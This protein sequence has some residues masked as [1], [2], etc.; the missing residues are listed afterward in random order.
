MTQVTLSKTDFLTYLD[1]PLHLWAA[2]HE[3]LED[4]T[5]DDY[6]RH[7]MT[8]GQEVE[9]LAQL[10]VEQVLRPRYARAE[11]Y[12]QRHFEDGPFL[13][14]ADFA[15]LDEEAGVYDLYEVKSSSSVKKEHEFDIAFQSLV[16]AATVPLRH[17][18]ILHLNKEYVRRGE[19]DI[20]DLFVTE[21]VDE[22]VEKRLPEVRAQRQLALQ[23]AAQP[24][25]EGLLNCLKPRTCPCPATCHP[26]LPEFPIYEIPRLYGNKAH[27]LQQQGIYAQDDIPPDFKLSDMQQLVVQAS[28]RRQPIIDGPAIREE[29]A[30]LQYPLYFIDYEA[31][32]PAVPLFDGYHPFQQIVFQYS[33]HVVQAPG[34]APRHVECL[35]LENADPAPQLVAHMAEHI[36]DTGSVLVWSKAFEATRNKEMAELLPQYADFLLD[37][38]R[39]IYD[40]RD[41][42]S[43]GYYVHPEFHGSTSIKYVLPVLAPDLSYHEEQISSG[44]Q[45][46]MAW[47]KIIAGEISEAE[48]AQ[49]RRDLLSYCELDTL[50]M[51][52]I[53]QVLMALVE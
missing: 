16:C 50:A 42:F 29:L 23:A 51:V 9:A 18:Y 53:W 37:L 27:Q 21:N 14:R 39:R 47:M 33:L 22:I 34:T 52:R 20:A 28:R 8:Q 2:K 1:A 49:I 4:T 40:L 45:A 43:K 24:E 41:I 3:R 25:P 10:Y 7:L 35:L 6:T 44:D 19:I 36:G 12:P 30:A 38:N 5:P 17:H 31:Y 32:N 26:R 15:A 11:F 13:A 48:I 46:M